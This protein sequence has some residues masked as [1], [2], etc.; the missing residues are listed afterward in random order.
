MPKIYTNNPITI[1][2]VFW[3]VPDLK[4]ADDILFLALKIKKTKSCGPNFNTYILPDKTE[5]IAFIEKR[6]DGF[7]IYDTCLRLSASKEII[8]SVYKT[9]KQFDYSCHFTDSQITMLHIF[10]PSPNK[11]CEIIISN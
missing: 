1:S 9:I 2:K 10:A 7:K 6:D 3:S 4:F 11:W 5:I 8:L